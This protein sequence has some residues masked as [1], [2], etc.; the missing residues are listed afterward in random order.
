M[1]K[2]LV[3]GAAG[4]I[5]MHV[6]KKLAEEKFDVIGIDNLN[7]YYEPELKYDRLKAIGIDYTKDR[8]TELYQS[9]KYNNL[10]FVKLNICDKEAIANL[11]KSNS[12]DVVLNLA[13]QAG[14]Q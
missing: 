13:A 3:T 9:S 10:Y 14:V 8:E 5:G 2:I 4:F 7:D 6:V 11:F 1:K 12:F